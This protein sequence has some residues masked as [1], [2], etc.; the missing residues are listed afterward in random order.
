[1]SVKR[2]GEDANVSGTLTSEI[3]KALVRDGN[4]DV[5]HFA[6]LDSTDRT[7][8]E[9]KEPDKHYRWCR[10]RDNGIRNRQGY[11]KSDNPNLKPCA[12]GGAVLWEAEGK[13]AG[14]DGEGMV[15]MEMPM[16]LY[17]ARQAYKAAKRIEATSEHDMSLDAEA[18]QGSNARHGSLLG[19]DDAFI[20]RLS[21]K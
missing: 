2:T 5:R 8:V 3:K 19:K 14:R 11:V 15:L 17:E 7:E 21:K 16:E 20:K 1:M 4:Y 12:P 13:Q 6:D 18:M 10:V 9:G